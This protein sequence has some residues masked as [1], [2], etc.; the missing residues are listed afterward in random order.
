[1]TPNEFEELG[2]TLEKAEVAKFGSDG[3]EK[4]AKRVEQIEKRIG[5]DDLAR[6]HA[7]ELSPIPCSGRPPSG[8]PAFA[9]LGVALRASLASR[10][11]QRVWKWAARGAGGIGLGTSPCSMIALAVLTVG[12]GIGTADSSASV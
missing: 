10:S 12:S 1:M 6:A 11:G 2:E 4:M 7:E 8:G 3:F 9:Q 5:T